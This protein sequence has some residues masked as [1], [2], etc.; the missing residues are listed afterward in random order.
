MNALATILAVLGGV[1][2]VGRI[3]RRSPNHPVNSIPLLMP[4][5]QPQQPAADNGTWQ[6]TANLPGSLV[7]GEGGGE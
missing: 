6:E 5:V 7:A 3:S 1:W 4:Q 2:L